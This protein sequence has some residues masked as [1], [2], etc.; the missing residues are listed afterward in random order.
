MPK[1]RDTSYL[2]WHGR[3][4]RVRVKVPAKLV[5]VLGVQKL[6]VPLHT[7]S[8]ALANRDKH[9]H[10]HAL[11]QRLVDA[12][13]TLRRRSGK[14][15]DPLVQEAQ[16]W[17]LALAESDGGPYDPVD[18]ALSDRLSELERTEGEARAG[19]LASIA[20][21]QATPLGSLADGWLDVKPLKPR[22]RLDYRRAV[23]KLEVWLASKSIPSTME[24]VTKRVA[25]DYRDE[26]FVKAGVHPRT[27]NKDLSVLSGLWK[28]AERKAVVEG[29]PWRGQSLTEAKQI[30]GATK[31]PYT[32]PE[33]A[34]LL[35]AATA[36]HG[37]RD[38]LVILALSGM[39]TEELARLKVGDLR[40]DHA[41]PHI[42]LRGTK[43]AAAARLVPVHRDALPI[44]SDRAKGK[45]KDAYVF[46]ELRTP[47][48]ESAMERGQPWTKAFGR[49]RL[50][51]GIDER[52]PGA[53]QSNL[54]LHGLRRW[55]ISRMRDALNAGATGFTMRTVAQVV[56][57]DV[58][59]L[60]LS[61][62]S[63]YAGQEPLEAKAAAVRAIKL[64]DSLRTRQ[65]A[66]RHMMGRKP[67]SLVNFEH[68]GQPEHI[69][70]LTVGHRRQGITLG[71]YSAGP[72]TEQ[73]RACLEAVKPPILG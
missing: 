25:S 67:Q 8:L 72:L 58:G 13:R 31:R 9:Q 59:D 24:A 12:E 27:A 52:Q 70:A 14:P 21:G 7:N 66:R 57:H 53:R 28:H 63:M 40:L 30:N 2:E 15:M 34:R 55:A 60:G 36:A 54:D 69:I 64:P 68:V 17:R 50:K 6:V 23:G 45:A 41:I 51:L 46:E 16:D 4:W 56:G 47:P 18:G 5:P 22:Q 20:Y 44:L 35:D 33:L 29:N 32:D 38:A 3:Q 19:L 49:L 61:M 62:T 10:L 48:A 65:L 73:V 71:R 39:R 26:V 1:P 42:Q 37:L 43:S 11:K